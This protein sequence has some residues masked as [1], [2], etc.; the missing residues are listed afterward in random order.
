[1]YPRETVKVATVVR[2][3]HRLTFKW[4][5]GFGRFARRKPLGAVGIG[6]VVVAT[7]LSLAA[8]IIAPYDPWETRY[9]HNLEA[10]SSEFW[11]GTDTLGRDVFSRVLYGGKVSLYVGFVTMVLAASVGLVMGVSSGYFGGR[12]DLVVQRIVDSIIAFPSLILALALVAAMK[13]GIT[14]IILAIAIVQMPRM[15]RVIRSSVLSI[16]EAPYIDAARTIG[17]SHFRIMLRHV[18]T[19]TFAPLMIVTTSSVGSII[20]TESSLSFLGVGVPFST[21][22]W[23]GMLGGDT[24]EFASSC[25]WLALA[26]GLALSLVVFGIN[27]FGDALRDVLDPRLRGF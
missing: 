19:N 7:G 16:K 24:R 5:I 3:V 26:P 22:S 20:I 27:M 14:N 17:A 13:P 10:P 18:A 25:V 6:L 23:G 8:P 4:L 9:G 1:M 2:V 21:I 15:T 11:F 12:Y